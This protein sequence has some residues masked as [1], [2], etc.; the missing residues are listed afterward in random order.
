[1]APVTDVD[2][3]ERLEVAMRSTHLERRS[4]IVPWLMTVYGMVAYAAFLAVFASTIAF[5]EGIALPRGIDDPPGAAAPAAVAVDLALIG[6]FAVQHSVMARSWS[7][8]WWLRF[9][10]RAIE[11]STYVL[12]S[13]AVLALA[14]WQWRAMPGTVWRVDGEL[15]R[16]AV[17][18]L[19]FA[20]WALVLG[21]TFLIDHLDMFGLR[22]V[23]RHQRGLP[24]TSPPFQTRLLYRVVR[25][26]LLLGLLIAVWAAPSMSLGRLLFAGAVTGYILLGVR[27]EERDLVARLG[28]R[29]R[30]YQGEVPM[31][32]PRMRDGLDGPVGGAPASRVPIRP[33]DGA[34]LVIRELV[35]SDEESL[36]A[37]Y[38]GLSP[39][40]L[41]RRFLT[42]YSSL[43]EPM[44][45][46]LAVA[47]RGD[48][49]VIV[50]THGGAIVGEARFH[51][52][53][54]PGVA[55]VAVVV[56]DDWQGRG[57]GTD[58]SRRL[59]RIATARGV[60][61]FTGS[62]QANNRAATGFLASLV[63]TADRRTRSGELEFQAAIP[64]PRLAV[65]EPG[66][67]GGR[68]G[69]ILRRDR[70]PA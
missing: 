5:V 8:R 63:P 3:P 61:T 20:G 28:G 1:M 41:S 56:A 31:L 67:D 38:R 12:T 59:A 69:T 68:D 47:G 65:S 22:Q 46:Y 17:V 35:S 7:K 15:W 9:V 52:A 39:S 62:I 70:I 26:P 66:A 30:R 33:A 6:L 54:A 45:R 24:Q 40:T 10:P 42:P 44:L 37:F 43:P 55:E 18:A 34:K 29:Y 51:L 57:L 50:A 13:S 11:R 25:H 58:L 48:R 60:T 23:V 4:G 32:V 64:A 27:L 16:G 36:R 14:V 2:R 49:C 53:G 21:S 19:S